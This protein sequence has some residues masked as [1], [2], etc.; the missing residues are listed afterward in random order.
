MLHVHTHSIRR[1][2]S[3]N[4]RSTASRPCERAADINSCHLTPRKILPPVFRKKDARIRAPISAV[5]PHGERRRRGTKRRCSRDA[6]LRAAIGSSSPRAFLL[7][8]NDPRHRLTALGPRA[9]LPVGSPT[10][11]C[12]GAMATAYRLRPDRTSPRKSAIAP[13]SLSLPPITSRRFDARVSG[14][15]QW[16]SSSDL[17]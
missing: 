12:E 8:H 16:M 9:T 14:F 7:D 11:L 2:L 5:S 4:A 13:F 6:R 1:A 3:R 10:T 17:R 15:R